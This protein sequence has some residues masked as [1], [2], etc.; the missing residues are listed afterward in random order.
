MTTPAHAA[1]IKAANITVQGRESYQENWLDPDKWAVEMDAK[2]SELTQI[3]TSLGSELVEYV[4]EGTDTQVDIDK[5]EYLSDVQTQID[6]LRPIQE[7]AAADKQVA[8]EEAARIAAEEAARLAKSIQTNTANDVR[9]SSSYGGSSG[10]TKASGVN[11]YGDRR[12]TYYSS[13]VLYH[14]RTS[15]WSQDA[16]GFYRT[17]D[18]YYVVA[19]SD[20]PQGTIIETSK[21]AAKVLDSGCAAGTTDFYV[22]F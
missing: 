11:Y 21:G 4:P 14:Y 17:S 2:K 1:N 12:E 19:A 9:A 18:G 3:L 22:G 6:R 7:Q 8:E 5:L 13:R 16:E 10:L 15:E 20:Y